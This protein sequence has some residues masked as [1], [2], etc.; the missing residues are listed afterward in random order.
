MWTFESAM[1]KLNGEVVADDG[2]DDGDNDDGIH[3]NGID[4]NVDA[5]LSAD[6]IIDD[7]TSSTI[8]DDTP[9]KAHESIPV[10]TPTKTGQSGLARFFKPR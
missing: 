5:Q 2:I 8:N 7:A 9:S 10:V 1:A 3:L 6:S 4:A